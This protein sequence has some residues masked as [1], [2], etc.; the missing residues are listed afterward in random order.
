MQARDRNGNAG[1]R[2]ATDLG[3]MAAVGREAAVIQVGGL[4]EC[5]KQVIACPESAKET[6]ETIFSDKPV[7]IEGTNFDSDSAKLKPEADIKLN[8]VVALAAKYQGAKLAVSGHADSSGSEAWNQKLSAAR[9]ESVKD[10]L[11][12]KGV[13]AERITS[14]GEA[15]TRPVAENKTV[16]GR[17]QNR[18]VEI[19][20]VIK[21]E[22]KVRVIE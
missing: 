1:F 2:V 14:K 10:Y 12:A 13:A 8:E 22:Q 18:R 7:T 15:A 21:E 20:S 19:N 11:V 16:E 9:A 5:N 17:A 3:G 4:V 6:F